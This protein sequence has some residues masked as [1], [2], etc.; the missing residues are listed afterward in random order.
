MRIRYQS[1]NMFTTILPVRSQQPTH[2]T[3]FGNTLQEEVRA[4]MRKYRLTELE[5]ECT[6]QELRSE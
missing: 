4:L 3:W 2:D 1:K 6:E 5:A